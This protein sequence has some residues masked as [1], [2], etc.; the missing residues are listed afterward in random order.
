MKFTDELKAEWRF[1][2]NYP[3]ISLCLFVLIIAFIASAFASGADQSAINAERWES[4]T[5]PK[6]R[7]HEVQVIVARIEKN[8]ARYEDV[9]KSTG[10]P[11]YVI[12]S[13][14][15]MEASGDF[16]CHL[17][18]GSSLKWRTKYV[19]IGR[20]LPPAKPPFSWEFSAKDAMIYDKM[21]LKNWKDIGDALTACEYYNGSGYAKY[22]PSTPTPYLYA[23]TSVEK[24]GKYIG[25]GKWSSTARSAQIGV[26]AI[27]KVLLK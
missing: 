20:P 13:L 14:H 7:L 11:W 23:G 22:H 4:A 18:E 19:P 21:H 6:H 26:V 9:S 16:T 3:A 12:A 25:D 24:A 1:W 15:N 5:I 2:K 8:K 17:H 27:W 10:V